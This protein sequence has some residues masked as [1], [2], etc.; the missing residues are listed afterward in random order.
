MGAVV[1]LGIACCETGAQE[2]RQ[3]MYAS[4]KLPTLDNL[5]ENTRGRRHD[6]D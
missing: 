1:S 3:V 4:R 5:A 2:L 6:V